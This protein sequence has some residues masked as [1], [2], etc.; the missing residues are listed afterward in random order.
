V[1]VTLFLLT[2][3]LIVW[4]FWPASPETQYRR[5]AELMASS[6]PADW[7]RGW[8]EYL[9]PLMQK[10]P[11]NPHGKELAE[12]QRQYEDHR[13]G[14][15]A[16]LAARHAGPMAEAQWFYQKGLRQEQEG[17]AD[18]ARKTWEALITA[19]KDVPSE[20]PWVRLAEQALAK[21]G[22]ADRHWEPVREAVRRAKQLR[23]EGR[24]AEADAALRGL[25]ELYRGDAEAEKILDD[26]KP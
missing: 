5:G 20:G 13:A 19:F 1:L 10:F 3:G 16:A 26:T 17:N 4:S 23:A 25:K 6:D 9:Q 24:A 11:D 18:G 7:D 14:R 15:Q 12:F 22:K 2:V 21:A 8:E